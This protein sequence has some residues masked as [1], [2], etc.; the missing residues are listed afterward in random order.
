MAESI[1]RRHVLLA[2]GGSGALVA[3]AVA[4]LGTTSRDG[5]GPVTRGRG[6]W[7]TFGSVAV[8]GSTF[9]RGPAGDDAADE[10][11]RK[12]HDHGDHDN[13]DHDHA[14]IH[15]SPP[16]AHGSWQDTVIVD[17][18]V[19]NGTGQ[20]IW[21]SPGQFR[22]RVG[23]GPSV[24]FYDTEQ[25]PLALAA[26]SAITSRISY[27]VPPGVRSLTVEFTDPED[28]A[29]LAFTLHPTSPQGVV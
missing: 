2:L 5:A 16:I 21:A 4:G 27:L 10:G 17:V 1:N 8:L 6:A 12:A 15:A 24:S 29:P 3:S 26:G 14:G 9:W 28:G 18:E 23:E 7:T 25:G 22:L 19:H 20:P 13:G 11:G